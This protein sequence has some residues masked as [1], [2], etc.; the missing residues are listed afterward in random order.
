[1]VKPSSPAVSALARVQNW[2]FHNGKPNSA[3]MRKTQN[4]VLF[5]YVVLPLMVF[6]GRSFVRVWPIKSAEAVVRFTLGEKSA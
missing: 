6:L 2:L 4:I 1:M 3:A 5:P